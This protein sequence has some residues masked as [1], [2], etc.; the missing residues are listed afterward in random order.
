[1]SSIK[2]TLS[3]E[4]LLHIDRHIAHMKAEEQVV[5]TLN[6]RYAYRIRLEGYALEAIRKKTVAALARLSKSGNAAT[7]IRL[8]QAE[9]EALYRTAQPR[10]SIDKTSIEM[11]RVLLEIGKHLP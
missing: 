2:L 5:A 9:V 7:S 1:M 4:E 6:N 3:S 10:F 11:N 8:E